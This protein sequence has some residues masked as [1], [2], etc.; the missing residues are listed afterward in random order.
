MLLLNRQGSQSQQQVVPAAGAS[1]ASKVLLC[2]AVSID[3][4]ADVTC[5]LVA[6]Q[7]RRAAS[8]NCVCLAPT[9]RTEASST[10]AAAAACLLLL[11]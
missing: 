9:V 10:G 6:F 11:L 5:M 7:S 4:C 2:K 8:N 3:V 1:G